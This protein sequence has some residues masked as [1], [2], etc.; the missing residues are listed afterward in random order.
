MQWQMPVQQRAGLPAWP[1]WRQLCLGLIWVVLSGLAWAQSGL[2]AVPALTAQVMDET[3]TLSAAQRQQITAKLEAI[4]RQHGSQV[5]VLMVNTTAPEDIAAYAHRVASDWK[6]GRKDTGDGL[7]FIIAKNDRSLRL[8]VARGLEGTIPDIAAGR[9]I[10]N[11]VVPVLRSGDFAA[12]IEAG[13][14][15]IEARLAGDD[16]LPAP[17]AAPISAAPASSGWSNMLDNLF[18][19]LFFGVPVVCSLLARTIGRPL[20]MLL[21]GGAVGVG[22]LVTTGSWAQTLMFAAVAAFIAL[23]ASGGGGGF[24]S[25]GSSRASRSGGWSSGSSSGRSSSGGFRSG[26][27]GSFGGGGA[28]GK[29]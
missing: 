7:L 21:I 29:W 2:L 24:S 23:C 12:A 28:S 16:W 6:I 20:T 18:P 25:G 9:I 17:Q 15:A 14:N 27:G 19:V 10:Q 4:E 22:T 11:N 3:G 13:L 5:V 8:E 1:L 26:G